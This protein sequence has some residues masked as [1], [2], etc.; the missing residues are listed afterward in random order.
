MLKIRIYMTAARLVAMVGA[1]LLAPTSYGAEHCAPLSAELRG[2][3]ARYAA[4]R[5]E[6]APDVRLEGG[7]LVEGSC[8]RRFTLRSMAPV[9]SVELFL[10]PDQVF[11]TESLFDTRLDPGIERRRAAAVAQAALL[12]DRSP[13]RGAENAPVRVVVFSDFQCPFCKRAADALAHIPEGDRENVRVVF[14]HRP[15]AMHL[16]ARRAATAAI[17]AGL[18]GDGAFW[19]LERFLFDNQDTLTPGMLD[20]RIRDF[21]SSDSRLSAK[22]LDSCIAAKNAEDVLL[23]D[24]KLANEYHVDAAPTIFINGV[25]RVGFNSPE[26]LWE[27]LRLA[28]SEARDTKSGDQLTR[29]MVKVSPFVER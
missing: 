29:P 23:R 9:R 17:C 14:K 27:A 20:A 19:A 18:Q 13:S 28:A 12:A 22:R 5:Y 24:E 7:E 21:A 10:S 1:A 26:A 16:W 2:R 25:R 15:L 3:I 11:V 8:F 6:L 4:E